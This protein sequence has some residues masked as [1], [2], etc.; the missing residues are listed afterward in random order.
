MTNNDN[1]SY[2]TFFLYSSLLQYNTKVQIYVLYNQHINI[3]TINTLTSITLDNC[4]AL[5]PFQQYINSNILLLT[6]NYS[7]LILQTI[8]NILSKGTLIIN[9]S[10]SLYTINF[11]NYT[12]FSTFT[13]QSFNLYLSSHSL[14][15]SRLFMSLLIFSV[16]WNVQ[17][18]QG[19][20]RVGLPV[21]PIF[22]CAPPEISKITILDK[23][24]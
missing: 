18:E 14:L 4:F 7:H 9:H 6:I 24:I 21:T 19:H 12:V 17:R 1:D 16:V 8:Y 20:Q 11:C 10:H 3:L 2:S 22:I 23:V 15:F 13:I 5:R